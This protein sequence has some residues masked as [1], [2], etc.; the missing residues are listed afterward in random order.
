MNELFGLPLERSQLHERLG[1]MDQLAGVRRVTLADGLADG[2]RVLEVRTG[3]G[4]RFEVLEGRG[5]DIGATEFR[6]IP[7][8]WRSQTGDVAAAHFET[9]G[10]GWLRSFHGGLLVGCGL[11]WMGAQSTDGE[12]PLGLHGRLSNTP[13]EA[14]SVQAEWQGGEH[15]I[16]IR[17]R[18]RDARVLREH[19]E[20][21]RTISTRLG[22]SGFD[23]EDVVTN[24]GFE[25]AT[26]ML[27][28]HMNFG[29]PVVSEE[30]RLL[31]SIRSVT[32]RDPDAE[33][34]LK[35]FDR[36]DGPTPGLPEQVFYLDAA[37]DATG[38]VAV[39]FVRRRPSPLGV[40]ISYP[41]QD[42]PYLALWKMGQPGTYVAALEPAN[43][44]VEGLAVEREK[45]RLQILEPGE[46]RRYRLRFDILYTDDA[47]DDF[48]SR[49]AAVDRGRSVTA[50]AN[51]EE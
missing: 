35:A 3:G 9:Q 28:Y 42:F 25:P 36:F 12:E 23:V 51:K 19:L 49:L 48:E 1:A 29:F 13:A 7:I 26:H 37:P 20:L 10:L 30:S 31:G 27:L 21:E 18:V 46:S 6:G 44:L 22:D 43:A 39:G 4:L 2:L 14:V 32:P 34:G 17:G 8:S 24:E 11:R 33:S 41:Q 5:L 40:A 16:R 15:T 47:I 38:T 45:G 50:V